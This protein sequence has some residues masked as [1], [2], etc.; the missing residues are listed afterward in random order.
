MKYG[1]KDWLKAIIATVLIPGIGLGFLWV[2][3]KVALLAWTGHF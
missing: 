2:I 3:V 1:F